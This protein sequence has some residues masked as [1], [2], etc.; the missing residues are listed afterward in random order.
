[1]TSF[2]VENLTDTLMTSNAIPSI[3]PAQATQYFKKTQCFCFERQEL[4]GRAQ[5]DMPVIFYVD[6]A[7]P[8]HIGT[9]TLSYTLYQVN[10][11]PQMA[12]NDI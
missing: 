10:D 9:I 3:S 5:K 4:A 1:M 6:P 11:P 8:S 2:T 12:R 7:L